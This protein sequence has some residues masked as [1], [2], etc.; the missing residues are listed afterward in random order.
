MRIEMVHRHEDE[1]RDSVEFGP[2]NM[3][4]KVYG[5]IDR[6]D[7]FMAKC[8]EMKKLM[9]A[10]NGE[11]DAVGLSGARKGKIPGGE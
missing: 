7:E 6:P 9:I 8:Q 2:A 5:C 4:A 3:R 1:E 11:L 10:L